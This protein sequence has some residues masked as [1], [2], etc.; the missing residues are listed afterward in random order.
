MPSRRKRHMRCKKFPSIVFPKRISPIPFPNIC[1]I[2][3]PSQH[4]M[5]Y[6]PFVL[7]PGGLFIV[8][9]LIRCP[10][11]RGGGEEDSFAQSAA[12]KKK[13]GVHTTSRHFARL[14]ADALQ[15]HPSAEC[16]RSK[17]VRQ[18]PSHFADRAG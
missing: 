2:P 17:P 12:G 16:V 3:P 18:H 6:P 15:I 1:L 7:K 14:R 8:S 10:Q 11:L 9:H 4:W 13:S 5:E